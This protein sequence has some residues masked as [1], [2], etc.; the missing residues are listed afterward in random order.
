M[1][2]RV[3]SAQP[4]DPRLGEPPA[5]RGMWVSEITASDHAAAKLA[6]PSARS[7][8]DRARASGAR[9]HRFE[10]CRARHVGQVLLDRAEHAPRL[11]QLLASGYIVKSG[12]PGCGPVPPDADSAPPAAPSSAPPIRKTPNTDP[13]PASPWNSP[14][15][16]QDGDRHRDRPGRSGDRA[17]GGRVGWRFSRRSA[18]AAANPAYRA[19]SAFRLEQDHERRQEHVRGERVVVGEDPERP[20]AA[21]GCHSGSLTGNGEPE[22]AVGVRG[23]RSHRRRAP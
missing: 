12:S 17:P 14:T 3:G 15:G 22:R 5:P 6:T 9:G 2:D 20:V 7:S 1:Q 16:Q 8:V 11:A 21:R 10:S 23:G 4:L 18:R 19:P 13:S